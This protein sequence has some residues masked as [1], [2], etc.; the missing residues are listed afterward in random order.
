M[1]QAL[2][3]RWLE[4]LESGKYKQGKV[5]LGNEADGYCCLGVLCVVAGVEYDERFQAGL[6]MDFSETVGVDPLGGPFSNDDSLAIL[7]DTGT[8]FT[9]IAALIRQNPLRFIKSI[10]P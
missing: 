5:L 10:E 6:P 2:L 8:P 1:K 7:N 3:D 9:A 4:A